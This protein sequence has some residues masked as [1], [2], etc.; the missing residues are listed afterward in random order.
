MQSFLRGQ[1]DKYL[2]IAFGLMLAPPAELLRLSFVVSL[3][4]VGLAACAGAFASGNLS[5]GG[6]GLD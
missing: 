4:G 2:D 1:K 6:H 5:R 3:A